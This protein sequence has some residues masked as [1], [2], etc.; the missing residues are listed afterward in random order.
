MHERYPL[1]QDPT[2]QPPW[3]ETKRKSLLWLVLVRDWKQ[4]KVAISALL[5]FWAPLLGLFVGSLL[6]GSGIYLYETNPQWHTSRGEGILVTFLPLALAAAVL[7]FV[8][9]VFYDAREVPAE[10]VPATLATVPNLYKPKGFSLGHVEN[11][12]REVF[13]PW[14][15]IQEGNGFIEGAAG[16]G[17]TTFMWQTI[18]EL[19]QQRY[20][21]DLLDPKGDTL[22]ML[23]AM[24]QANSYLP[25][26]LPFYLTSADPKLRSPSYNVFKQA[27][28]LEF[29]LQQRVDFWM[30]VLGLG[31]AQATGDELFFQDM[32]ARLIAFVLNRWPEHNS[33]TSFADALQRAG[34]KGNSGLTDLQKKV[35]HHAEAAVRRLAGI[36]IF[37]REDPDGLD[38]EKVQSEASVHY[39]HIPSVKLGLTA[40]L[41]ARF[42]LWSKL[43]TNAHL[44]IER[45]NK[46][47]LWV[48]EASVALAANT[49]E[50][51]KQ[52]RS[53]GISFF[54]AFQA[55][56]DLVYGKV[57]IASV[58][59]S[60]T[61]LKIWKTVSDV[62]NI[63]RLS[64]GSGEM[65]LPKHHETVSEGWSTNGRTD[66]ISSGIA[67][68]IV[69][70]L[71]VND[72]LRAS[73][74]PYLTIAQITRGENEAQYQGYPF[75]IEVTRDMDEEELEEFRRMAWPLGK[76][77][78]VAPTPPP[79]SPKPVVEEYDR[80]PKRRKS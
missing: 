71:N 11:T 65:V 72:I 1:N 56:Q 47:I 44:G 8:K 50:L 22:E 19:I 49:Q 30:S 51:F 43:H 63:I 17:K 24:L 61:R 5:P 42:F 54:L 57:D 64:R 14:E 21:A 33:L 29:S 67:E 62:D 70:R 39:L 41:V 76:E 48:D 69:P 35:S 18:V 60:N 46:R 78:R 13:I 52:G 53:H 45:R 2:H 4:L 32:N 7:W 28:Y 59:D 10:P 79:P 37:N 73:D 34:R 31:N 66:T 38:L 20:G 36:P 12:R 27:F 68:Q 58:V 40:G 6:A 3:S 80:K 15:I 55:R 25:T 77:D 16:S 75:I 26:P 23:A 74:S 9:V